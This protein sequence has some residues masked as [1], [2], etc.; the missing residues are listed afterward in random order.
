MEKLGTD[1][2]TDSKGNKV[3]AVKSFEEAMSEAMG[4]EDVLKSA[5]STASFGGGV[6]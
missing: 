3:R 4:D 6:Q 1:E 5:L 2:V